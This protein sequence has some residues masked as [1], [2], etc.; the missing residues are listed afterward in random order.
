MLVLVVGWQQWR[1]IMI[2]SVAGIRL[3]VC[4]GVDHISVSIAV[5]KVMTVRYRMFQRILTS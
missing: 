2:C 3:E 5:L 4:G 1:L